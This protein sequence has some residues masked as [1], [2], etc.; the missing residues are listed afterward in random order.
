MSNQGF[1]ISSTSYRQQQPMDLDTMRS[2]VPSAFASGAHESRSARY[3]YI[4]TS[5]VISAMLRAGFQPFS[6]TQGTT[7][8]ASK[9]EFTKHLIRFRHPD[10]SLQPKVGD[11]VPEV[12]LINSHDGSTAYKLMAG[13]WRLICSNGLMVA[14]STIDSL[15]VNHKG[16]IA[17]R[18]IEGS[19]QLVGQAE[20]SLERINEW[21]HLQLTA[22]EQAAFAETAHSYRFADDQGEIHTPITPAQLLTPR[23][24]E[25]RNAAAP[26]LPRPDLWHT[27]NVVQ[28]NAIRGGLHGTQW[29]TNPD[30]GRREH[31][32]ITTREIRG[33]DQDVRLN[34]ALWSLS[35]KMAALKQEQ[36]A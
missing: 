17:D 22:G 24:Y 4:P 8:D 18:V 28:E 5:E 9:S 33:I 20:A 34:K 10:Y 15:S 6:A 13:L 12:V 11:S 3:T 14:D 23:R 27:M 2:L 1:S 29:S 19:F 31:K 25:D 32:R 7:R 26:T 30:T 36:A 16:N 35:E 21:N